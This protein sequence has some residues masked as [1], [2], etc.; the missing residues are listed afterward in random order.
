MIDPE[1]RIFINNIGPFAYSLKVETQKIEV[2]PVSETVPNRRWF[3]I[4]KKGH[5]HSFDMTG[6]DNI[7]PTLS[8]RSHEEPYSCEDCGEMHK[9]IT[10][11]YHCILCREEI[12]PHYITVL[13]NYD[14]YVPGHTDIELS[15]YTSVKLSNPTDLISFFSTTYFG[16]A[17]FVSYNSSEGSITT[18]FSCNFLGQRYPNGL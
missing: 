7:L 18:M 1:D 3:Q 14:K 16:T 17:R 2:T 8:R 11:T 12:E 15:V 10:V 4:D 5:F 13:S 9:D 6:K